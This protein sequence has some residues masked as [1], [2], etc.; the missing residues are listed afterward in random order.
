MLD[1]D[2]IRLCRLK[3]RLSQ[4]RLGA[5]VGQDQA[6]ISRLE[7]GGI[8]D[9]TVRTLERL[10]DVL[11]VSADYLLGRVGEPDAP[12]SPAPHSQ[13]PAKRQRPRKAAPVD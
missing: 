8:T 9:I 3:L 7:R 11:G 1:A 12:S 6:Y 13:P 5:L 4:Q 2:R 10:A